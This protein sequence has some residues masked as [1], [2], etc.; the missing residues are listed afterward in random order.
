MIYFH[1]RPG[2]VL[3]CDFGTCFKPPEMVKKR[4]VVVVSQRSDQLA[5]V[6]PLSATEPAKF[7][8]WHWEMSLDSLPPTLRDE[9]CWAKCDMVTCVALSRLDRV[10]A[11]K[12]PRTGKRLFVSYKVTVADLEQIRIGLREILML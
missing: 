5:L 12:C 3:M 7:E 11:G 9:R 1:P 8:L 2:D 10:K 4:P 6:V